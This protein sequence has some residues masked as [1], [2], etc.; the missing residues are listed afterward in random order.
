MKKVKKNN[1]FNDLKILSLKDT[2]RHMQD[3]EYRY[4]FKNIDKDNSGDIDL[5]ELQMGLKKYGLK[6]N[7]K[8]TKKILKKYDDK[9]DNKID[10]NEFVQ[11][12]RD[13]DLDTLKKKI[14]NKSRKTIKKKNKSRKTNKKK[15]KKN[16]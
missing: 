11:L 8:T 3:K 13:I 7:I 15:N 16:C 10:I 2:H 5:K 9:P 1:K 14:K 4:D 6:V 12:K